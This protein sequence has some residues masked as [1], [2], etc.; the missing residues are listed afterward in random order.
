[1]AKML[2]RTRATV[3]LSVVTYA[4]VALGGTDGLVICFAAG[5]HI[6]LEAASS[7]CHRRPVSGITTV[8]PQMF[9]ETPPSRC[10]DWCWPCIDIPIGIGNSDPH[11]VPNSK[12]RF[13]LQ[14]VVGATAAEPTVTLDIAPSATIPACEVPSIGIPPLSWIRTVVLLI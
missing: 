10:K 9:A 13:D 7:S 1:M 5:S 8:N 3:W 4:L 12:P 11:S 14:P 6:A 2:Q